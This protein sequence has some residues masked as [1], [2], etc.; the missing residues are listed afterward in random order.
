MIK[1][2]RKT[3]NFDI[4]DNN[5]DY[6][7]ISCLSDKHDIMM[8]KMIFEEDGYVFLK[9]NEFYQNGEPKPLRF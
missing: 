2:Q 3:N 9:D 1:L 5:N 7:I 8:N 4:N 6:V